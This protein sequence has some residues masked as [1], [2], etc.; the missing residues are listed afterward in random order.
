MTKSEYLFW[1]ID[2]SAYP[3]QNYT[4]YKSVKRK[5]GIIY[6]EENPKNCKMELYYRPELIGNDKPKLPVI[7]NFHGGGF[8]KGDMSY[9]KSVCA[10]FADK[11]YFVVNANYRLSPGYA[12][13]CAIIDCVNSVNYLKTLAE[14]Y[15][16]DLD[17]VC[18]TGDSAGAH[19]ATQ[20]VSVANS[21]EQRTAIGA[22][23]MVVRPSA[24]VSF[25]GPYDLIESITLVKLPFGLLWDIG[26]CYLNNE[27]F[28]LKEDF[29]NVDEYPYKKYISPTNFVNKDWCPSFLVIAEQD[30]FCKG[31]G[32]L[33]SKK[34]EECGVIHEDYITHDFVDNHCFHLNFWAKQSKL[35]FEKVFEF[36][37]KVFAEKPQN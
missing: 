11:G 22:P 10:R 18:V 7:V 36:L 26:K 14:S 19:F 4:S 30:I 31:Q 23:E 35:C 13:P 12:F 33:L 25:C 5:T 34:M 17:K 1:L 32:E 21:E 20:V 16:I 24:L 3:L 15:N 37:D 6:D 8:V 27:D 9:R 29:S 2:V 28:Q